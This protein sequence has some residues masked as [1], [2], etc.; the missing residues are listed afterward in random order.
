MEE[1][2]READIL[3]AGLLNSA[4]YLEIRRKKR[5]CAASR[6]SF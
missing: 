1:E 4:A 2:P 6:P 5:Q 3:P